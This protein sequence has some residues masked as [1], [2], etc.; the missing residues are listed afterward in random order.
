MPIIARTAAMLVNFNEDERSRGWKSGAARVAKVY[1]AIK[2]K[3]KI[4]YR[5]DRVAIGINGPTGRQGAYSGQLYI[6]SGMFCAW[7]LYTFIMGSF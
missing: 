7:V 5:S 2:K 3:K 4:V 6:G 1:R